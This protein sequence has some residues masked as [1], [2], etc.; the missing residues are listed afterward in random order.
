MP[1]QL[2]MIMSSSIIGESVVS[3]FK[4]EL[5]VYGYS[6]FILPFTAVFYR[7]ELLSIQR[8]RKGGNLSVS[9][10]ARNRLVTVPPYLRSQSSNAIRLCTLEW[11]LSVILLLCTHSGDP[12]YRVCTGVHA[13]R[14]GSDMHDPCEIRLRG[15]GHLYRGRQQDRRLISS[16]KSYYEKVE[17]MFDISII[18]SYHHHC[19]S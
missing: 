17:Q 10:W 6:N 2:P 4:L 14:W 7:M 13:A 11:I 5:F 15:E 18:D 1:F 9:D 8:S 16:I 3:A 19:Q 12:R